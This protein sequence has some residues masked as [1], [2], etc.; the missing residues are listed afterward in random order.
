MQ[1][2]P[3]DWI[4][5]TLAEGFL[6]TDAT[7]GILRNVAQGLIANPA[8]CRTNLMREMP[9]L[10]TEALLMAA[11]RHGAD[12]QTTH[13]IIRAHSRAV[14][15]ELREGAGTNDLLERL[16]TEPAFSG[17]SMEEALDPDQH[18]GRAPE[19]VDRFIDQYLTPI[20]DR[21][22]PQIGKCVSDLAI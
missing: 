12:R 7:L 16:Q 3:S 19:Q 18:I 15:A 13:E 2:R 21:Y 5:K 22:T 4:G 17:V 9:F 11:V 14:Q 1:R 10:A 20:R 8:V 6:A